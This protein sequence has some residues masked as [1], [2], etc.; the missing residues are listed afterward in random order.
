MQCI[1]EDTNFEPNR[2]RSLLNIWASL[3]WTGGELAAKWTLVDRTS[4]KL[5]IISIRGLGIAWIEWE[6]GFQVPGGQ[7]PEAGWSS[8]KFETV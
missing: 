2:D 4:H 3:E 8:N 1:L 6:D 7:F 5:F